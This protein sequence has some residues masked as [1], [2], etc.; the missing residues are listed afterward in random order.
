MKKQQLQLMLKCLYMG[1]SAD[2]VYP[3]QSL[4]L[5]NLNRQVFQSVSQLQICIVPYMES[6]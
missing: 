4:H 3:P 6:E 2:F 5:T 1:K